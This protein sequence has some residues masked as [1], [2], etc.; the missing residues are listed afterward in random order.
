MTTTLIRLG[1]ACAVAAGVVVTGYEAINLALGYPETGAGD[2]LVSAGHA[3]WLPL[4]VFALVGLH[5]RQ[6]PGTGRLGT[7]GFLL[8]MLGTMVIGAIYVSDLLLGPAIEAEA[9]QIFEEPTKTMIVSVLAGAACFVVGHLLFAVATL[10]ARVFPRPAAVLYL[11][12]AVLAITAL[13]GLPGATV[14]LHLG[15]AWLGWAVLSEPADVPRQVE[16]QTA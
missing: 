6:E 10:R 11:V 3:L 8:A 5:L 2:A 1:A 12:G 14:V 13:V 4:G 16:L 9:P 15:L 7:S